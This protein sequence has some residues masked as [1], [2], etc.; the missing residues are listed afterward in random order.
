MAFTNFKEIVFLFN[1]ST[2]LTDIPY[3]SKLVSNNLSLV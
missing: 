2:K 1:E 3:K